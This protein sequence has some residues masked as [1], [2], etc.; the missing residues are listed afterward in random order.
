MEAIQIP[1]A[2]ELSTS[3]RAM[4]KEGQSAKWRGEFADLAATDKTLKS[5]IA[6]EMS[7]TGISPSNTAGF[8]RGCLAL[9]YLGL[10][11]GEARGNT[12]SQTA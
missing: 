1:T 2:E 5:A 12:Q 3:Y 11:I 10:R 6:H 8:T 7:E 9:F 4:A